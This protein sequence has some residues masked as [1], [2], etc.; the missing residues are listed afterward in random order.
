MVIP[1]ELVQ[2]NANMTSSN[3]SEG[4]KS[5]HLGFRDAIMWRWQGGPL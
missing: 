2:C 4:L 5:S 3:I 1:K